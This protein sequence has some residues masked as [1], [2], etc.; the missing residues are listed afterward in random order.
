MSSSHENYLELRYGFTVASLENL[1][2]RAVFESRWKFLP[3][4]EK[5]EIAWSAIAEVL[6]TIDEP[7][8]PHDL[9]RIGERAI[10]IEVEHLSHTRG[11]YIAGHHERPP[12]TPMVRYDKYWLY[13]AA[14][15]ESPEDRIIDRTALQQ[16]WPRLNG[17]HQIV[18]MAL[19]THGDYERAAAALNK[20]HKTFTTQIYTARKQ[21]LR[22][23]H[24]GEKPSGMWARD[25]V[26]RS[27]HSITVTTIRRRKRRREANRRET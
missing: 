11:Y 18:L 12:G 10:D 17:V 8:G 13:H 23:W 7:P 22:L 26:G 5:Y 19:A 1:A 9:I 14:P 24:E 4:H 16:I 25:R 20:S 6:Y 27:P 3:F 2:R 21:F 15:A